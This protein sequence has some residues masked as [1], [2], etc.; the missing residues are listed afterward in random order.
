MKL[1]LKLKKIVLDIL[2]PLACLGCGKEDVWL[3]NE[4]LE[5]IP[6]E[7]FFYC[8]VCQQKSLRGE[9]HAHCQR[10]FYLD[11]L[12]IASQ[13]KNKN[14]RQL[15]HKL[16]YNFVQD[17]KIPLGKILIKKIQQANHFF[18]PALDSGF[19]DGLIPIPLAQ[20]RLLWRGFNQAQ[21][22]AE[23]TTQYLRIPVWAE[24]VKRI[25]NTK[26]QV[27]QKQHQRQKNISGAFLCDL[28]FIDSLKNKKI[29]LIDDVYTTGATILEV[30]KVLK[31]AGTKEV[32]GLVLAR[33]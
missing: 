11:G 23:Q 22:L 2:F 6:L 33:G 16:K 4:C 12:L 18:T 26:P 17:L 7:E 27:G 21:L 8:A 5:K 24:A 30:A 32:W 10:D 25:K 3:C 19:F 28:K 29:L 1:F 9:T 15:I 13:W 14:L 31:A 20:K